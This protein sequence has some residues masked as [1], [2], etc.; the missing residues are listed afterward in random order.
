MNFGLAFFFNAKKNP[1]KN[2][3]AQYQGLLTV[4]AKKKLFLFHRGWSGV[5][6]YVNDDT[7]YSVNNFFSSLFDNF[8]DFK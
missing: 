1:T 6:L 7:F 2:E 5:T 8:S 3:G 4:Q